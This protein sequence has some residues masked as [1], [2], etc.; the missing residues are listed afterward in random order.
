MV[1]YNRLV[2]V[3]RLLRAVGINVAFQPFVEVICNMAAAFL[4][5]KAGAEGWI[6]FARWLPGLDNPGSKKFEQDYQ[7]MFNQ[8]PDSAMELM[9][10]P[11]WCA[12]EAIK[13]AGTDTDREAIAQAARSGNLAW[14]TPLGYIRWGTDVEPIVKSQLLAEVKNGKMVPLPDWQ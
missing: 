13:L 6:I 7:A 8:V 4:A 12:I 2:A 10:E 14:E 1:V 11:I 3:E 9:Y 5:G